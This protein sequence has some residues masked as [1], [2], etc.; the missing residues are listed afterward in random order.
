M[1]LQ[2]NTAVV[3]RADKKDP[4]SDEKDE[5]KKEATKPTKSAMPVE[6]FDDGYSYIT[7]KVARM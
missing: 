3:V 1:G 5:K 6:D 7:I 4:I 2:S